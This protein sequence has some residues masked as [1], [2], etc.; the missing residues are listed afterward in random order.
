VLR[1][2]GNLATAF[3][4][5]SCVSRPRIDPLAK[6]ADEVAAIGEIEV[7]CG[8]GERSVGDA[9]V[10]RLNGQTAFGMPTGV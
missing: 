4:R 9:V 2:H 8:A 5:A 1:W 7:M 3:R 6:P 10:L